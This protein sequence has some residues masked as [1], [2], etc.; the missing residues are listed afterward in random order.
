MAIG[1]VGTDTHSDQFIEI[2]TFSDSPKMKHTT[3]NHRFHGITTDAND[4]IK[5]RTVWYGTHATFLKKKFMFKRI[6]WPSTATKPRH[7]IIC[8]ESIW[9]NMQSRSSLINRPNTSIRPKTF[10]SRTEARINHREDIR[11]INEF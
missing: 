7:S 3:T 9:G 2:N 5:N 6:E 4:S 8:I 11:T 10:G 1:L